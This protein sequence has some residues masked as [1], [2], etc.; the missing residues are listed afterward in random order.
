MLERRFPAMGTEVHVVVV[1]GNHGH[2]DQA[3]AGV[4]E[5]ERRWSRFRADSELSRLNR[6][7]G[8]PVVVS[9]DTFALVAAAVDAHTLTR[10]AFDPTVLGALETAGYDRPLAELAA[11][12]TA[13]DR[14]SPDRGGSCGEPGPAPGPGGIT[15]DDGVG[16]VTLP[17]GCRLDLGGIAKGATA[18]AVAAE[19]V[20]AGVGGCCVNLGGDLRVQGRNPGGGWAVDLACP[21]ADRGRWIR[22]RSGAVC[23]STVLQR[24]WLHPELGPQHH[25]RCPATG[26]PLASG[27]WSVSVVAARATQAEVLTKAALAAGPERAPSVV[28]GHGATG[29]LVTDAGTVT[30]LEGLAP[31]LAPGLEPQVAGADQ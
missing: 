25:L 29:V 9:A 14:A 7:Q 23:T 13:P 4:E 1:D 22:L 6:S 18:D 11:P 19:L 24:T 28:A 21:G 31:F 12:E 27:L 3:Q 2:L 26:R 5:R 16:A 20:V 15:L 30:E 17:V 10:G 8:R